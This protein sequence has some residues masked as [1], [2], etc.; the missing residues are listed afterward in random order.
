[1]KTSRFTRSSISV[2]GYTSPS[3]DGYPF[4]D[5]TY[6]I[7]ASLSKTKGKHLMKFGMD[8]QNRRNLDDGLFSANIDFT[9][10]AHIGPAKRGKHRSS[11]GFLPARIAYQRSAQRRRHDGLDALERVL[12]LFPG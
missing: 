4:P 8:Y 6:Q 10:D 9:R 12:L 3:Q 7:L 11:R 1:M 5:D 2:T